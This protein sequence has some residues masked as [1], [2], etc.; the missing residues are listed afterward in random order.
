MNVVLVFSKSCVN[1][2]CISE[3]Q[4]F[5]TVRH[6][7]KYNFLATAS[8]SN[9]VLMRNS[10]LS[11]GIEVLDAQNNVVGVSKVAAAQVNM[12]RKKILF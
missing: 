2:V 11:E 8:V 4:F 1:V 10:E 5:L 6:F 3:I 12:E 7:D 9:V